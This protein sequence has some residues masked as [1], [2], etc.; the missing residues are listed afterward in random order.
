MEKKTQSE[1]ISFEIKSECAQTKQSI[2]IEI[3]SDLKFR[4]VNKDADLMIYIPVVDFAKLKKPS[5]IDDF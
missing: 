2:H 3:D 1:S 4:V 5:I